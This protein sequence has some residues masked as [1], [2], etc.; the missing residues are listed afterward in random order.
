MILQVHDSSSANQEDSARD[1]AAL[2]KEEMEAHIHYHTPGRR[3]AIGRNWEGRTNRPRDCVTTY[4][5][6]NTPS[7][8]FTKGKVTNSIHV[9]ESAN[10]GP[11]LESERV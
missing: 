7:N 11:S 5:S 8:P 9:G 2:L 4:G 10:A 6:T 3:P 1:T